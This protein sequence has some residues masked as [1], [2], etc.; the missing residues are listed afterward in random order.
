ME[1]NKEQSRTPWECVTT[2][3]HA[4]SN[5]CVWISGI[6]LVL[7]A[8][9]IFVEV[10]ARYVLHNS[11]TGV[12]EICELF[13]VVVLYFGLAYSTYT[14][15]HVQIDVVINA[16][17]P[18]IRMITCGIMSFL[19]IL[20]CVPAAIQV[21]RQGIIYL[22]NGKASSLLFIPHWPFYMAA[23]FGLWL[24]AFEFFCDGVKWFGEARQWRKE[25]K[26]PKEVD[27]T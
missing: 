25:N 15:S 10:F 17:R 9:L 27:D 19:C 21:Y 5:F 20:F 12:Q 14:R 16:F 8:A 3:I 18:D 1:P 23:S 6:I 11:I 13:I 4:V 7:I 24:T 2:V 22:G 26:A